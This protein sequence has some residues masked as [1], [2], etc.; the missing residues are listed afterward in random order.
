MAYDPNAWYKFTDQNG[1]TFTSRGDNGYVWQAMTEGVPIYVT[2]KGEWYTEP[3]LEVTPTGY[4]AHIPDWFRNTDEYSIWKD[5]YVSQMANAPITADYYNNFN[6]ILQKLGAQ[7]SIRNKTYNLGK[8]YGITDLAQ[9]QKLYDDYIS[10]LNE[11]AG[12]GAAKLNVLAEA[13]TNA[14]AAD[15]ARTYQ[16]LSKEELDTQM[17]GLE[18]ILNAKGK[19]RWSQEQTREALTLYQLLNT[20]A[21]NYESFGDGKEFEKLLEASEF[22]KWQTHISHWV[23][24]VSEGM[25]L[26]TFGARLGS[27]LGNMTKGGSFA[28]GWA[29]ERRRDQSYGY[30]RNEVL[31][32]HLR[33][34]EGSAVSGDIA[35]GVTN[36]AGTIVQSATFGKFLNAQIASGA[37]GGMLNK[38]GNFSR[39]FYGSMVYDWFAH[40][41]PI[42]L[43]LFA[44]DRA[45]GMTAGEA[46]YD[47]N[48]TQPLFGL[49]GPEVPYGLAMN[50]V[51]D[52]IMDLAIPVMG[53]TTG[54][55]WDSLDDISGGSLTKMREKAGVMALKA[56]QKTIELPVIGT[57][58]QKFSN[59][60]FG[61]ENAAF[62]REMRKQAIIQGSTTPYTDAQNLLTLKN[63]YGAEVVAPMY[64]HLTDELGIND[65]IDYFKKN[66]GKYGGFGTTKVEWDTAEKGVGRH[67]SEIVDDDIPRDVK[68]ALLDYQRLEELKG[69][70]ANEG[71][72][73]N[74][75]KR[76]KEIA[77]LEKKVA[78]M[79]ERVK[80][81]AEN[82]S[83]LNKRVEQ[84]GVA[85]G[86]T[87]QDWIDALN[88]DPRWK[89][90]MVRQVV[91]PGG[92][93]GA[94][95][96]DPAG[97]KILSGT[98]TG[99]YNP[100]K[101]LSPVMSLDMKVHAL[102][103]AYAWN[104]RA[105][106]LAGAELVQGKIR[107]GGNTMELAKR[108]TEIRSTIAAQEAVAAKI[109]YDTISK[110]ITDRM[111]N[112]GAAI[113]KISDKI[114]NLENITVKSAFT[115][116]GRVDPDIKQFKADFAGD[117]ISFSSD[118]LMKSNLDVA[119]AAGLIDNTYALEKYKGGAS[120]K[121][122]TTK[123]VPYEYTVKD[124]KIV[125]IKE[126]TS[127]EGLAESV[128]G[129]H[130]GYSV[131]VENVKNLG[132]QNIA[133]INRAQMFYRDNNLIIPG[134]ETKFDFYSPARRSDA[135]GYVPY[136]SPARVE[137]GKVVV[138]NEIF[139]SPKWYKKG[140]EKMLQDQLNYDVRTNGVE[141]TFHPKNS[142]DPMGTPLHEAAHGLMHRLAVAEFNANVAR[143][144]IT[145]EQLEKMANTLSHT[146]I[147]DQFGRRVFI[148]ELRETLAKNKQA[149]EKEIIEEALYRIGYIS[150]TP[151]NLN[152]ELEKYSGYARKKSGAQ[153]IAESIS[154]GF[155]DY[156]FNGVNANELPQA[157]IQVTSERLKKFQMVANPGEI[158]KTNNLD[159]PTR[160]MKNGQ[161]NF[162]ASA[163]TQADKAKWLDQW[164]QK[165]PYLKGEFTLENF[166]KAN[167]WDSYLQKEIAAYD[168][169]YKTSAPDTLI[170]KSGEFLD[171]YR[172]KL[173]K[174]MVEEVNKVS[175][176]GFDTDLAMI[177]LGKN[178]DEI[179]ESMDNYII[180][181]IDEG[182][183]EIAKN[184][185]GGV[186]P[187]NLNIARIT[188]WSD[189]NTKDATKAMLNDLVPSG[190]LNVESKVD[191]LFD[192]QAKGLASYEAL[193]LD[194]T[195]LLTEKQKLVDQIK[196]ENKSTIK[197]AEK[198]DKHSTYIEG[199]THLIHFREG[200]EDVYVAVN[201]PVVA[202]MLQKPYDFK[203]HGM[204][205]ETTASIANF[206]A[207]TYRL[208][209]TGIN[210]TAL[211]RNFLRDPIQAMATAGFNPLTM[212][213]SPEMFYKTLRQYGLDDDTIEQVTQRIRSWAKSGT[214][215]EEMRLGPGKFN[216][217]YN[218]KVDKIN[219]K[220][221]SI[222]AGEGKLGKAI[223]VGQMPLE[224]WEG[225]FRNQIGQQSFA[226]NYKRTRDV[227][228][229]LS[230]ALFDTSNATTN[231]SHSIANLKR[232]TGT[233][234]YLS[235][236][237]NGTVSFWRLFTIDPIGMTT[238]LAGGVMIPMMAIT[239]WNLSSEDN[240]KVYENL[241]E[242]FKQGHVILV[243]PT[244]NVLAFPLPEEIQQFTGTARKLIEY[245]QDVSPYSLGSIAA[246]GA[247]GFAPFEVDG[248]FGEDGS[249]QFKKGTFQL[250][251]GI[252]P[253]AFT[254]MYEL[255]WK[256]DLF[257]GQDLSTL[258]GLNTALNTLTNMFGT[259]FKQA[260]NSIGIMCGVSEKDLIG[261]SYQDT[262]ARDL[263][264]MGFNAA[265]DQFMNIVGNPYKIDENGKERKATGLFAENEDL[266][267]K[268]SSLDSRIAT[269]SDEEKP[270]L[271]KQK[272][273]L[274]DGFTERVSNLMNNY[275]RMFQL[276]G[277][278]ELWQKKR[279][280]QVL[281]LGNAFSSG[282]SDS[283]Q[284]GSM[285]EAYLDERGLALQRYTEM[286]LPG[287]PTEENL[288]GENS[289]EL[290][291]AINR[292]YGV[293]KQATQDF[294]NAVESS[295]LK[296]VKDEFYSVM[297]QI[298]DAADEQGK[299]PD[300]DLIERIQA[301]YLQMVD[302]ILVP[303][304]NQY[305]VNVLNNNDFIDA[306]RRQVNGMIPSD[307]WRQSA[308]NAK[309]FLSTKDFPTAT[310][311]VK[312]WLKNRYTSGMRDRGLDSDPQVTEM[313]DSIRA[314]IDAGRTG[315]AK[316]KID[317]LKKGVNKANY[318]ISSKDLQ[319]LYDLS[320]MLK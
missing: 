148:S 185:E 35:G 166:Q 288:T 209:T 118:A 226:K 249:L 200:G 116:G 152:I 196:K 89:N 107:S 11:G 259:G 243:D 136:S 56:Q 147:K 66:A 298:Y 39:T 63:H 265:R 60:L 121:G 235:S 254:T 319:T 3:F 302:S 155:E 304:V 132:A 256:E 248:Y 258:N 52:A 164:R 222:S 211:L 191:I 214:M 125:D 134:T 255:I 216:S 212:S 163:K 46:L 283:Y 230:S 276:T 289:I 218:S 206:V 292:F 126:I 262:I 156:A 160:M 178:G 309:K 158:L 98:R 201:D 114:G 93:K 220:L 41:L 50:M 199:G 295:G 193:P 65:Q 233:I 94:G 251:S 90:Y 172:A 31:G 139:L 291:A 240:R 101:T 213:L 23:Q 45:S 299:D 85:L 239:M 257:T 174:E 59:W 245:T 2:D 8:E 189:T 54:A 219:K 282:D 7:G 135:Y 115:Q 268:I 272:Q 244:G 124:K 82:F 278:L 315:A 307:D 237:I 306:V 293:N 194:T 13:G 280:V 42:D 183:K 77:E 17:A 168:P 113:R 273:D 12:N 198:L 127:D 33:G 110:G 290:Q 261:K 267:K 81:F 190:S 202:S 223:K 145:P 88:A 238:R 68:Q 165:N 195:E 141:P 21:D 122:V 242:W 234:P 19:G 182:A 75:P 253:Q 186:T 79:P 171:D 9:Q 204:I 144:N 296:D 197:V 310:V 129:F 96:Y 44:T 221:Q 246:Q 37:P 308:R 316:G 30:L 18:N 317:D 73:V 270:A 20:V 51:G 55:I 53:I 236:A 1:N 4:A 150:A 217:T 224:T 83:E 228:K 277:G 119:D 137:N 275:Q 78:D 192:T 297:Q 176:D 62:I 106:A 67:L 225:F 36:M 250:L 133:A 154:E 305:G 112:V 49:F 76:D 167:L 203:K 61:A 109:G 26:V 70:I 312:K 29:I 27:G 303:I 294:K 111:T 161:Y 274:I 229:A 215:T 40:D 159:A 120:G 104:E 16:N 28:E 64:K 15:I 153:K 286:G 210:P 84:M 32:S 271:E 102:G 260:I 300:Y 117:R 231:F 103:V 108:V 180:R 58:L 149:I 311:D 72:I 128:A 279:L 138:D 80:K 5:Q 91:L 48:R 241:P 281:T 99:Y 232:V 247:F 47:P 179:A 131:D 301:R 92:V 71:G 6:D 105:K 130:L 22:Q 140:N 285:N 264:G 184:M 10:I 269:A 320:N 263:F 187:E 86:L 143:L 177:I 151:R 181:Q 314:D 146:R 34:T 38:I 162:P 287:G 207:T 175:G 205:A 173:A 24:S 313:L 208:G 227:N 97:N 266:R 188:L 95:V 100:E 57:G 43:S 123:G 69:E 142:N 284:A 318:Y 25:P 87:T 14:S 157:I 74:N 169:N 170:N 252:M